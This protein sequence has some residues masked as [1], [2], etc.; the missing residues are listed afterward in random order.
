MLISHGIRQTGDVRHPLD[1]KGK[2]HKQYDRMARR[3]IDSHA[4]I[5]SFGD[6]TLM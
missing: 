4:T 6:V 1:G 5:S 3:Q 2:T